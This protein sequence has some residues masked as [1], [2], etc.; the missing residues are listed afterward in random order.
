MNRA[1]SISIIIV[2]WN[3]PDLLAA[4]LRSIQ[5]ECAKFPGSI[6]VIVV[7]NA[8][9]SGPPEVMT[10]ADFDVRL[11]A[12]DENLGFS[13]ANNLGASEARG[14][15]LLFLNPDTELQPGALKNMVATLNLNPRFALVAPLLLNNDGTVQSSG[16]RFPGIMNIVCDLYPVPDRITCSTANGR[17]R[18]ADERLPYVIDYPLGAAML[19]RTRAFG[20]I[21]GFDER[22]F[23]YSEEV[24]L[25]KRLEASGWKRILAPNVHIVHHGGQST[26][27]RADEMTEHLWLSR[28]RYFDQWS[29]GWRRR[30]ISL[31]VERGAVNLSLPRSSADRIRSAFRSLR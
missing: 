17:L 3:V 26:S 11:I 7:D 8:S 10:E 15:A 27:Q 25:C 13:T 1:Q 2:H 5:R 20:E 31:L 18:P 14:D 23:M 30:V 29:S 16:Y 19:V 4:C 12:L 21:G 9:P 28:A 6:E 22:Y 24:D